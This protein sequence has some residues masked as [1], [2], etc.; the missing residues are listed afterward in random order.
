M[1]MGLIKKGKKEVRVYFLILA[2]TALGLGLSDGVF[3]NYFKEAYNVNAFQRGL[4]EFPRELPGII[5]IIVISLLTFLG[6]IR[7]AIIAQLLSAIGLLF[8]G[9]LT[10]P[11][12]VMCIFLFINSMGMHLFFPLSDGIGMS[13]IKDEEVGKKMG[14]YK[15]VSTAFSML[16]SVAVFIGFRTGFFSLTAPVKIIFLIAAV[17]F[18][19]VF[20][21]LIY[22]NSIVK[23]P[24]KEERKLKFIFRKEYKYY[25]IL[26]IMTGVQK[27]IMA[28]YGPWVLIDLLSKKADTIAIL[29]IIGS[30][31]GIFFIP[32]LGRWL[33]RYGIRK[34]LYVDAISFIVVY[35]AYGFLASGF[36]TGILSK[37]GIP[38]ILTF[39]LIILDRMS[40][41]M[42]MIKTIYL[43]SIAVDQSEI[44]STLSFGMSMDHIVS[45]ICAYIGGIIWT[46]FGPQYIFFFAAA[47]SL[48]NLAVAKVAVIKEDAGVKT[49]VKIKGFVN[50]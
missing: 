9:F 46:S 29:G 15:G 50:K 49:E 36:S 4:I 27:Q 22:M 28:V 14:R 21:L 3:S 6:D 1:K 2:L 5:S 7:I 35:I 12:A 10:P 19:V 17:I 24:I 33:D 39:V 32:A 34:M 16:A 37:V 38:V 13:L 20:V 48:V 41:Q 44:T 18:A 47:A 43:R 8:L 42:S 40:M 11:F 31:I 30:F 26:A 25:Y 45:I 23:V